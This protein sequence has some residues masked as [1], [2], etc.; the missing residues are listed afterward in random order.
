MLE[1]DQPKGWIT[2][3]DGRGVHPRNPP[4]FCGFVCRQDRAGID[5]SRPG[6]GFW[7][8]AYGSCDYF[9]FRT[10]GLTLFEAYRDGAAGDDGFRPWL[11]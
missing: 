5:S 10:D 9:S 8:C 11:L 4:C 3:D 6:Y 2:W 7:T 1:A